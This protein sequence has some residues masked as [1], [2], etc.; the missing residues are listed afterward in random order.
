MLYWYLLHQGKKDQQEYVKKFPFLMD[1]S[2]EE[3]VIFRHHAHKK[4]YTHFAWMPSFDL[5]KR[6]CDSEGYKIAD[7]TF[8]PDCDV[9]I[10]YQLMTEGWESCVDE[11]IHRPKFLS[12]LKSVPNGCFALD[13]IKASNHNGLTFIQ[14]G[15]RTFN[16]KFAQVPRSLFPQHPH[17]GQL[18]VPQ[19]HVEVHHFFLMNALICDVKEDYDDIDTQDQYIANMKYSLAIMEL[20]QQDW[21][22]QDPQVKMDYTGSAFIYTVARIADRVDGSK[23]V[24]ITDPSSFLSNGIT[25]ILGPVIPGDEPIDFIDTQIFKQYSVQKRFY[26][27]GLHKRQGKFSRALPHLLETN[28]LSQ[29]SSDDRLVATPVTSNKTIDM[30]HIDFNKDPR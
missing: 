10:C 29:I 13:L 3:W 1:W 30:S 8:D 26:Q 18:T 15:N 28:K 25:P 27:K 2:P 7:Q 9:P 23:S 14:Y 16:P 11:A 24:H 17:Q 19:Y 6:S 4:A 20:V 22:S 12:I 21:N 5:C